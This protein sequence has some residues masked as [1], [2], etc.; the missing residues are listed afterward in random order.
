[1]PAN[2]NTVNEQTS[3]G[4][5]RTTESRDAGWW[6]SGRGR[7]ALLLDDVLLAGTA[8]LDDVRTAAMQSPA[9]AARGRARGPTVLEQRAAE[10]AAEE[11]AEQQAAAI[12]GRQ[13]Q[14]WRVRRRPADEDDPE[15]LEN[16]A[17]DGE[18]PHAPSKEPARIA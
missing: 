14:S 8:L 1:M 10:E 4:G 3:G 2:G 16:G 6:D 7:V 15:R 13:R 11:R 17:G 9:A 5:V 18:S 12:A